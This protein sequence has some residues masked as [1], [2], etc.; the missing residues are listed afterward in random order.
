[1]TTSEMKLSTA[2]GGGDPDLV[3]LV[4][5]R[6]CHDLVNPMGAIGN[7]LELMEMTGEV[8]GDEMSLVRESL[9]A[10]IARIKF[11]RLAFGDPEGDT[12]IPARQL[13][14]IVDDMYRA[15]KMEVVWRDEQDRPR[16]E[17]R[18]ACLALNCIETAVPW[19]GKVE[20]TRNQ[21][22]WVMH[23]EAKRLKIDE[24]LWQCLGRG[25]IPADLKGSEVQFGILSQT[26]RRLRRPVSVNADER[27]LSL[28]V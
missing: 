10:A 13:R 24:M 21:A 9:E 15:T 7:G 22:A 3:A 6:I 5:S 25:G 19:G 20:V 17:L 4:G 11:F 27:H 8:G 23:V 1:M 12:P 26:S 2:T 14:A 28:V 16:S 18:L